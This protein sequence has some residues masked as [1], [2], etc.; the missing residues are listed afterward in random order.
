MRTRNGQIP[1]L[2]AS[3]VKS[4][5]PV[6]SVAVGRTVAEVAATKEARTEGAQTP[7]LRMPASP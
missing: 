7:A 1:N 2:P 6:V 4:A 3:I 5:V